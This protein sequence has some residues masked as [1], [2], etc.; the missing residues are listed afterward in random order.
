MPKSSG[1]R[2]DVL[3]AISGPYQVI[4]LLLLVV[5]GLL[6][7]W[8]HKAES[9]SERGFAGFLMMA[10]MLGTLYALYRLYAL[11][12]KGAEPELSI[13][14]P[15]NQEATPK[16][17][18]APALE[19]M[20]GPDRSYLINRPPDG[21]T[22]REVTLSDWINGGL[23]I[24]DPAAREKLSPSAGQQRDILIFD[25]GQTSI[26]PVPGRTFIN[27]RKFPSALETMAPTQLSIV[28]LDRYEPPFFAERSLEDG[29]L[30]I[31]GKV[32]GMFPVSATHLESGILASNGRRYVAAEMQQKVQDAIVNGKD[33]QD[34]IVAFSVFGIQGEPRDHLLIMK[35][36]IAPGDP[37]VERT[38]ATLRDLVSSFR[39]LKSFSAEEERK[40]IAS[41]AD[42]NFAK[43]LA[44]NG[45]EFFTNELGLLFLRLQGINLEDPEQR[46]QAIKKLKPFESAAR[47]YGLQEP[48]LDAFWAA[49][50]LAETGD[51][52]Q[53]KTM[54]RE[55]N[56]GPAS[57]E[58]E[59]QPEVAPEVPPD[60]P[61]SR[62]PAAN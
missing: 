58:P 2:V 4:G 1:S 34:I 39:P 32:L 7:Y 43:T 26:L 62:L 25:R 38:L 53:F 47:E 11:S 28:P 40:K 21:W 48:K 36:T 19:V 29:F 52:A 35:Y 10:I 41:E 27:G 54:F 49:L 44:E 24:T 12:S 17:I 59:K 31:V 51:A 55:F 33:G 15:D 42:A 22:A 16:E 50:H 45:G 13:K 18:A 23:D 60:A 8:L 20:P 9:G 3:K 61:P 37:E 56:E 46:T 14:P 6:G 30:T 5:E 57:Q